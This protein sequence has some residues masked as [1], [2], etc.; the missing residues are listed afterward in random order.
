MRIHL[1]VPASGSGP[2]ALTIGNFDGIHRGHRAMLARLRAAADQ[3]ALP[4]A[5]MT[6]EP[7][8]REFFSPSDAPPRITSLREKAE[9]AAQCG[10]DELYVCRFDAAFSRQ[11]PDY[12][13]EEL[14]HR[15]L[16][17]RWLLVGD[18]FRFGARRAGDSERLVAAGARLG[19][20]CQVMETVVEGGL[21]VSSSAVREALA[22]GDLALAERLLGRPYA[23][24]GRVAHGDKLG[25]TLGFPTANIPFSH[26]RA[27]LSGIFAVTIAGVAAEPLPAVASLGV[28]PTVKAKADPLLEVHIFDFSRDIY[29]KRVHVEFHHK[30][31]DEA[32]YPDLESLTRQIA[33]DAQQA[34]QWF[35]HDAAASGAAKPDQDRQP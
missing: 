3:R 10:V 2:T 8:P 12:F 9:L 33:V 11:T 30:L 21:R 32:R 20:S 29:G 6:F 14:L 23:I 19:F 4:A 18:D 25:R 13:I 26:R 34:R 1:G 28:R 35:A 17:V 27:A 24:S 31:R 5:L 7:H 15:R 16:D 22:A